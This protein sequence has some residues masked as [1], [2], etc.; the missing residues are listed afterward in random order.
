[1]SVKMFA[2]TIGISLS[3]GTGIGL[4]TGLVIATTNKPFVLEAM[5]TPVGS[6]VFR[7]NLTNT[8]VLSPS[9]IL[10][11]KQMMW[12]HKYTA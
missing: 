9:S 3:I 4:G 5:D 12:W 2:L 1:M 8:D 7:G 10:Q 11:R 6:F